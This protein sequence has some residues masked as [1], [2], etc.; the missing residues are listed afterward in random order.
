[1]TRTHVAVAASVLL[2]AV[3]VGC[4]HLSTQG[5]PQNSAVRT[6]ANSFSDDIRGSASAMLDEGR[7]IFRHDTFGD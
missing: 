7:S 3:P 1:M 5:V 4:R 2:V 6:Q